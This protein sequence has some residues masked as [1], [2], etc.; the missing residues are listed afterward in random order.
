MDADGFMFHDEY[1]YND[2]Y[3]TCEKEKKK[4]RILISHGGHS[5]K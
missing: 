4:K 5:I 1:I 2:N 3:I